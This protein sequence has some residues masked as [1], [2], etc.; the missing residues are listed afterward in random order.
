MPIVRSLI[1]VGRNLDVLWALAQWIVSRVSCP[2][3]PILLMYLYPQGH[4][5]RELSFASFD[6]LRS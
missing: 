4:K 1:R 5:K 2:Q 6:V 3:Y